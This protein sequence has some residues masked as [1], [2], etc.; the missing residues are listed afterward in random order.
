MHDPTALLD[1]KTLATM[2]DAVHRHPKSIALFSRDGAN[3][4][5]RTYANL[6]ALA[7]SLRGKSSDSLIIDWIVGANKDGV[8]GTDGFQFDVFVDGERRIVS[9][10]ETDSGDFLVIESMVPDGL[11]DFMARENQSN[12]MTLTVRMDEAGE[13]FSVEGDVNMLTG[14]APSDLVDQRVSLVSLVSFPY[15]RRFLKLLATTGRCSLVLRAPSGSE[16]GLH[17]LVDVSSEVSGRRAV[18]MCF[19][20]EESDDAIDDATGLPV[21]RADSPRKGELGRAVSVRL[22]ELDRATLV[23]QDE[24]LAAAWSQFAAE[25]A[26]IANCPV[27]VGN[28]GELVVC[29]DFQD[30]QLGQRLTSFG[31]Q[32]RS[33]ALPVVIGEATGRWPQVI[34]AARR[35]VREAR[36]AKESY[37]FATFKTGDSTRYDL[38]RTAAEA[39]LAGPDNPGVQFRLVFQP[40]VDPDSFAIRGAEALLRWSTPG[41]GV[42]NPVELLHA[43]EGSSL[44]LE[45]DRWVMGAAVA[46]VL[47]MLRS[48]PDGVNVPRIWVNLTPALL[49]A[50]I[51]VS[52]VQQALGTVPA[53]HLGIEVTEH[54]LVRNLDHHAAQLQELRGLGVAV[55]LD[56]FG[57]GSSSLSYAARLPCDEIK[58]D[59]SF[60]RSM[61]TRPE[62]QAVCQSVAALGQGLGV[63]VCAEQVETIEQ[64][65]TLQ[66]LGVSSLQGWLFSPGV[67]LD[68]FT[69]QV[70]TGVVNPI[71]KKSDSRGPSSEVAGI[72]E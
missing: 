18:F 52:S 53:K 32:A 59:G 11:D 51:V 29:G 50:G 28:F 22:D 34:N 45:L 5:H 21:F 46:S 6:K 35:A 16:G 15:Q 43:V 70:I 61:L 65:V 63:E 58:I 2:G 42:V 37:R 40:L 1:P 72:Q 12:G 54:Q 62:S 13:V 31:E 57:T 71:P 4:E 44:Q 14:F 30:T 25:L 68:D 67:R 7:D 64:A 10:A 33:V 56:D 69:A 23:N 8:G 55:A 60:V 3:G 26:R 48:V 39:S 66:L 38:I 49:D 20:R 9:G 19:D 27:M 24:T 41:L 47:E 36:A 17:A